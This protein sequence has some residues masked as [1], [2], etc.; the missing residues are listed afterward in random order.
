LAER[1]AKIIDATQEAL[2]RKYP[3]PQAPHIKLLDSEGNG[4]G[5]EMVRSAN[6]NVQKELLSW[7]LAFDKLKMATLVFQE[8][9]VSN[10]DA[11]DKSR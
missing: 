3:Q 9:V 10:T 2:K 1:K 6:L 7:E 11:D 8:E 4:S 5:N